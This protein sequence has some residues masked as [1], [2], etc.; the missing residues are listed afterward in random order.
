MQR[1]SFIYAKLTNNKRLIILN[2]SNAFKKET[3]HQPQSAKMYHFLKK[4]SIFA[5]IAKN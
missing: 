1:H 2:I 5:K 3:L 4:C